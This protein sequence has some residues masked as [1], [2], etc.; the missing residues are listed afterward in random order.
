ME[1]VGH[2]LRSNSEA[3]AQRARRGFSLVEA[4]IVLAVVGGVIGA[5]WVA[6]SAVSEKMRVDR[7][8]SDSIFIITES[9]RILGKQIEGVWTSMGG[10][11]R[12][13]I[14]QAMYE[15]GAIPK[16]YI[17]KQSSTFGIASFSNNYTVTSPDGTEKIVTIGTYPITGYPTDRVWLSLWFF[18]DQKLCNQLVSAI[19]SRFRVQNA[20]G[21][22]SLVL[23]QTNNGTG[24]TDY[25][26]FPVPPN[27]QPCAA[28]DRTGVTKAG[29]WFVFN[30]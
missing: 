30:P 21:G 9:S 24:V 25:R 20:G 18:A 4:A 2:N 26:T 13:N 7:L 11:Q 29:V 22:A 14:T 6:A 12:R 3:I 10:G 27:P 17:L 19:S 15:A 1:A 28:G 8:V 23:I 16:T 5:I